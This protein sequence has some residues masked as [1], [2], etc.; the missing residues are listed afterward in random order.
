MY[1][2]VVSFEEDLPHNNTRSSNAKSIHEGGRSHGPKEAVKLNK[3]GHPL[4]ILKSRDFCYFT[5]KIPM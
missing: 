1:K 2:A 3:P 4:H 5:C